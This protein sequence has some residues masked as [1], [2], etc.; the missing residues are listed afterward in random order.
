MDDPNDFF[1]DVFQ[2]PEDDPLLGG[3]APN[4]EPAGGSSSAPDGP[5]DRGT[6]SWMDDEP[7]AAEANG[8][9][10]GASSPEAP[11]GEDGRSGGPERREIVVD[12]RAGR[13]LD[14][15]NEAVAQG[16]RLIRISLAQADGPADGQRAAERFVAILEPDNPQSLFDFGPGS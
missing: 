12:Q 8:A 9:S 13:G 10:P 3:D 6:P 7:D 2:D 4:D 14:A 15:L 5:P 16:W 1:G 11:P